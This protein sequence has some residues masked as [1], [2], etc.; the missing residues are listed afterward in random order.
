MPCSLRVV[1]ELHLLKSLS[2]EDVNGNQLSVSLTSVGSEDE[3][4]GGHSPVASW[5]APQ[6]D[7]AV[8]PAAVGGIMAFIGCIPGAVSAE[9]RR[10]CH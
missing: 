3:Q 2:C 6:G 1:G 7:S 9:S 10:R 4:L 8:G 5:T